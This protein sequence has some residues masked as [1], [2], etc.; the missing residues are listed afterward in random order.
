MQPTEP[1]WYRRILAAIDPDMED[2]VKRELATRLLHMATSLSQSEG[3]E[4]QFRDHLNTA[5][6]KSYLRS[7]GQESNVRLQTFLSMVGVDTPSYRVHLTTG[8]ADVVIP[9]LAKRHAV[10]LVVMGTI[11]RSG[12]PGLSIGN[13]AARILN[14]LACSI[15]TIKP[16]GLVSPVS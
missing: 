9:R 3:A 13:T 11:G 2:Q 14:R 16:P 6:F 15:F 7:S 4:L 1:A 8:R 10:D 12:I 5:E